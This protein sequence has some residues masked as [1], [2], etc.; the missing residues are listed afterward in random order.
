MTEPSRRGWQKTLRRAP[1][2]ALGLMIAL[3]TSAVNLG[4]DALQGKEIGLAHLGGVGAGGIVVAVGIVVIGR[5]AQARD[6][7][8]PPGPATAG[9]LNRAIAAGKLPDQAIAGEWVPALKKA[10]RR[11]RY[12][13]WVG[14][15]EFGLFTAL[16]IFLIFDR[17][18]HPWF[19]AVTSLFSLGVTI[20]IPFGLRR[21]RERIEGLIAQL[22]EKESPRP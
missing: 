5:W 7:K 13:L 1:L 22:S 14:L 21:R 20:W 18:D 19:G 10:I 8:L 3:L 16:G 4:M 2:W 12:M 15:L 9:N 17:P 11:D 6:R